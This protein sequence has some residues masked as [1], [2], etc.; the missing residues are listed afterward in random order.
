VKTKA[1]PIASGL[2][3]NASFG[4]PGGYLKLDAVCEDSSEMA[5]QSHFSRLAPAMQ[6]PSPAGKRHY[7]EGA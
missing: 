4:L 6:R 3:K 1:N 7:S 2:T 5:L